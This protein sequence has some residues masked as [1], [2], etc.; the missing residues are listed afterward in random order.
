MF[1][2]REK[3]LLFEKTCM[4]RF[5]LEVHEIISN[6]INDELYTREHATNDLLFLAKHLDD[7]KAHWFPKS[8]E[9]EKK[10]V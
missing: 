1:K 4:L 8:L 9:G 6:L 2:Q 5:Q 10:N 3:D 7:Q